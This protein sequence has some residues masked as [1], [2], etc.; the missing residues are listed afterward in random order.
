[1]TTVP[2]YP[3]MATYAKYLGGEPFHLPLTEDNGFLPD[4]DAV[5]EAILKKAKLLYINYPNNP[6]GTV[7]TR[8]FFETV[9]AFAH[10]HDIIVVNDAA[11]GALTYDGVPP[12]SLLSIDGAVEVGLEVHSLSKA[13]NMTGWRL[14]FL[15]GNPKAIQAY[16]TIK[17]NTDSGQFR[18]IQWAGITALDQEVITQK[19]VEKYSRRFNLLVPALRA[20]GFQVEKPKGGF[21]C[22]VNAP[23][24]AGEGKMFQ[25]AAQCAEYFI[26]EALISVVPWDDA[27]PYLRFSVTFEAQDPAEEK[28]IIEEMQ[29]RLEK[30][31]LRFEI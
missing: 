2:G 12:L 5:S 26:R 3:V 25:S 28:Q 15:A 29:Q 31:G 6:T 7:A 16:A 19:T 22:Y 9:V 1:M 20:V 23:V 10:S 14:G 4:L 11:Y 27:G 17:D 21:Y 30:L 13:F 8:R 24:S 18:A